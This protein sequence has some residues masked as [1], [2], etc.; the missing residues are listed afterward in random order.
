M[1]DSIYLRSD[2]LFLTEC[3]RQRNDRLFVE[4]LNEV[5]IGQI[6]E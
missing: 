1:D 3:R 5:R 4:M 2:A 6:S